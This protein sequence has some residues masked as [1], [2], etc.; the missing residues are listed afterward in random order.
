[1][2]QERVRVVVEE[3]RDDDVR[4]LALTIRQALLMIVRAIEK[5][6]DLRSQ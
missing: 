4:W 2:V 3:P 1:M 6:Y 5:R